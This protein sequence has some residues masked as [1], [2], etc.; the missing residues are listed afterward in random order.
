M[1]TL[2]T[3]GA[4]LLVALALASG[5][6]AAPNTATTTLS[7]DT[8]ST[9]TT[10]DVTFT[11]FGT[12]PV[13]PYEYALRNVCITPNAKGGSYTIGQLDPIVYWTD[14]G[15]NGEP[16]VTMPVYL[17]SVPAGSSCKVSLVKNNTVVKG[18][19]VGYSVGS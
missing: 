2:A 12:A 14:Q 10:L 17:E 18:S 19:T 11:V 15:P 5:A 1:K 4:A 9:G 13:V 7:D 3:F 8:P 16:R 6:G